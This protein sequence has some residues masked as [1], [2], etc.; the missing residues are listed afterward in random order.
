MILMKKKL[1]EL[2]T[3]I[4]FKKKKLKELRILKVFNK[5]G[6]KL[7][8]EWKGYNNSLNSWR[9]KKDSINE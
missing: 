7:Y 3:K 5:K 1:L 9:D 2:F 4:N 8:V 6:D